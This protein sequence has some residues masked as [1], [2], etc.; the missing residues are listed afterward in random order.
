VDLILSRGNQ[1]LPIGIKSSKAFN[2]KLIKELIFRRKLTDMPDHPGVLIYGGEK[3]L[4]Y[5]DFTILPWT[6][7]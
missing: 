2:S 6:V 1:L 4:K 3:I 5:K 7:C